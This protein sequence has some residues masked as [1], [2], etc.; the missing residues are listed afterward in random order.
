MQATAN[1]ESFV[2][3]DDADDLNRFFEAKSLADWMLFL[4]PEQ[5]KIAE[6]D[7][8][9]PA[10][11]RGVSGSGKTCVLVHR[12]RYLA[13]KYRQPVLLVTLTESMRKLLEQMAD[14]LCGVE[15][16]LIS[17]M[18]MSATAKQVVN[19]LHPQRLAFYSLLSPDRQEP[20]ISEIVDQVRRHPDVGRT[21]FHAMSANAL[22]EFLRD[23]IAYVRSRLRAS[24]LEQYAD[25]HSFRRRGRSVALN[26]L[27]RQV[28]LAGIR[29]YEE[30]M[31]KRRLLDHE[32]IV[33]AGLDQLESSGRAFDKFRCI[34]CDE[35]QD[36]SQLELALLAKTTTP[37]GESMATAENGLFLVGD[38]AQT[39]YKRGFTFR[40][41]GI[42][43]T[44]RS[45]SL[46]KNYRNTHE[47]LKAAFGLVA[48]YEFADV[49]E[50]NI[51]R[52]SEPELA[53][54]HGSRPLIVRCES[55]S[56]E[57]SAV[58]SSVRSLLA[59]GHLAGQI[60]VVG[61]SA[62]LRSEIQQA[63]DAAG[64]EHTDLKQ[65]VNYE[66]DRVKI[67]TIE[68][69]KGHEFGAVFIMGLVEGV[70]P[71]A[72]AAS[73]EIAREASRL[74]VAMT[75]AR[76]NLRISYSPSVGYPVSRFLRAIQT[77]CDEA[78]FRDGRIVLL[79]H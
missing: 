76:E 59:M 73:E 57:A 36:L 63:L 20:L 33:R 22:G 68:S 28:A 6:K 10:R 52:P 46:R 67:S 17:A 55:P 56:E 19:E 37:S 38:G 9:G 4:H 74:Y 65:D 44:S 48:Q 64:I 24:E 12:A 69:A 79:R 11:L 72:D 18:T 23:E 61:P 75:R 29:S 50:D 70:L 66:S 54:R 47:I 5:K 39:I 1:S 78:H 14:D 8:L 27:A 26:E 35:V 30:E 2:T 45:F 15:R 32:G 40:R 31:E 13:K 71:M 42:D 7:F 43:V 49:D 34:L 16:D 41:L 62:K 53:K 58:T 3:F 21:P 51:A 77:D 60:C 25:T